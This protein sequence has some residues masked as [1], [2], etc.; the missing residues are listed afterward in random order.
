MALW[1]LTTR[2]CFFG[3]FESRFVPT[4]LNTPALG[5]RGQRRAGRAEH[6]WQ[7]GQTQRSCGGVRR[8]PM[9]FFGCAKG[10]VHMV[11]H[12]LVGRDLG[13]QRTVLSVSQIAFAIERPKKTFQD[14]PS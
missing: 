14:A 12:F 10:V 7:A 4:S 6:P 11:Y 1:I 3:I 9:I 5:L 2:S 13:I 8:Q